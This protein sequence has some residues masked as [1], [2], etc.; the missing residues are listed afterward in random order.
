MVLGIEYSYALGLEGTLQSLFEPYTPMKKFGGHRE[1]FSDVNIEMFKDG[2]IDVDHKE[3]VE[4]LSISW[5]PD[6]NRTHN[7]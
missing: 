6:L 7:G 1:C 3:V 2:F 4:D 5:R